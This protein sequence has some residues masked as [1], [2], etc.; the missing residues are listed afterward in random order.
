MGKERVIM[1][2]KRPILRKMCD[3]LNL[4][5]VNEKFTIKDFIELFKDMNNGIPPAEG[6]MRVLLG[7]AVRRGYIVSEFIQ[8]TGRKGPNVNYVK[9]LDVPENLMTTMTRHHGNRKGDLRKERR[10]EPILTKF[11]S[12]KLVVNVPLKTIKEMENLIIKQ[13]TKIKE[14]K[15]AVAELLDENV[16]LTT[17]NK[18]LND[19]I[20]KE[21]SFVEIDLQKYQDN[22]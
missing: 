18:I 8:G 7:R 15:Q 22:L 5:A 12:D 14:M 9:L 11:M 13:D 10:K 4:F 19:R 16:A 20:S 6:T 21:V 3:L 1:V 2:K 17:Q